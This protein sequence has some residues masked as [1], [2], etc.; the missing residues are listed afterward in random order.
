MIILIG[1]RIR[2]ARARTLIAIASGV[3]AL[4]LI[5]D[6]L[7]LVLYPQWEVKA[8]QKGQA[9]AGEMAHLS[10]RGSHTVAPETGC[11]HRFAG[12]AADALRNGRER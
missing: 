8:T 2:G 6:R 5:A 1:V 11:F 4:A 12:G 3:A 10:Q 7:A 9:V